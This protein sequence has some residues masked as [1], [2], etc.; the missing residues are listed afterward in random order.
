MLD[1]SKL[2]NKILNSERSEEYNGFT[3][4]FFFP[5]FGRESSTDITGTLFEEFVNNINKKNSPP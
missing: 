5:S 2:E 1:L 3:M 4:E